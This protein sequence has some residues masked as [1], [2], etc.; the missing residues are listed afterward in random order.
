MFWGGSV[1]DFSKE[2][3]MPDSVYRRLAERIDMNVTG[4]P[5]KGGDFS[6]AFLKYLEMQFTPEEAELA[7]FL[8]VNPRW[9]KPE[10]VADKSGR[11]VEE[12]ARALARLADRGVIIG[13]DGSYV[14]PPPQLV[15]NAPEIRNNLKDIRREAGG[16]YKEFF[17]EDG[18]YWFYQSSAKGTPRRRTVPVNQSIESEQQI[19]SHEQIESFVDRANM[20][21]LALTPCPC[22]SRTEMLGERECRDRNP[23][24]SCL[25]LGLHAVLVTERGEGKQVTK[26]EALE[27]V[28]KMREYGLVVLTDNSIEMKDGIICFCCGCCCSVTRGLSRWDNPKAFAKS[29]FVARVGEDCSA[30]GTCVD[31]CFFRALSL[32]DGAESAAVDEDRCMGCGVCTVTC[33]TEA[34]R[35]E[36]LEREPIFDTSA[37]MSAT[38]AAENEAAGQKRPLE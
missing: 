29:N 12:V 3:I 11:P 33:P 28:A 31:R 32:P 8:S 27:Y 1:S 36:R 2:E 9:L 21:A 30:C 26:E 23:V 35:L 6:P 14:L 16:L 15:F 7:S 4:A 20:G 5:K 17:I 34:L 18:Y 25:M 10:V 19:L 22:R 24:A 13:F 38:V 37:Q